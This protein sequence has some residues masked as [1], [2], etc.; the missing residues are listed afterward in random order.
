[1]TGSKLLES[2]SSTLI[3]YLNLQKSAKE[4]FKLRLNYFIDYQGI[5]YLNI[6]H[7][8]KEIS[9]KGFSMAQKAFP[10]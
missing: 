3:H 1:M 7:R 10:I 5:I 9:E 8:P 6:L 4:M 2:N